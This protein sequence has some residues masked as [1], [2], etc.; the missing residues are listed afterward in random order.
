M[1]KPPLIYRQ[2][3]IERRPGRPTYLSIAEQ[4]ANLPIKRCPTFQFSSFWYFLA[5]PK[6]LLSFMHPLWILLAT[7]LLTPGIAA[8]QN[9]ALQPRI[10]NTTAK[11]EHDMSVLPQW[12]SAMER[13]ITEDIPQGDC[14]DHHLNNCH[15][16][17]WLAFLQGI[18]TAPRAEQLR[19]VNSYANQKNYVLDI[20]NY[21]KDDYWAIAKEFFNNGGDCEDYAITKF[22]SLR[23]LG[24]SNKELRLLILQDT[25]LRV[26]HAVLIVFNQ[27]DVL[28]LDNQSQEVLSQSKILHY[29]PLYSVNER[30]WWLHIPAI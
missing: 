15:L 6:Y 13:H 14:N 25:N 26:Q 10:F 22:F 19:K 9:S 2:H 11:V 12:L 20:D 24:Y 16:K 8:G 23:W 4:P 28:V 29:V 27:G 5:Q 18:K 30:L 7:L 17:H 1:K 21:G 3:S